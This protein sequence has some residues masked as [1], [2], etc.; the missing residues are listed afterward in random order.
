M[1]ILNLEDYIFGEIIHSTPNL[2]CYIVTDKLSGRQRMM[3][4]IEIR[5]LQDVDDY[6]NEVVVHTRLITHA[7]IVDIVGRKLVFHEERFTG[8]TRATL[9][10][11]FEKMEMTLMEALE[12][13][14]VGEKS[15]SEADI[16][17]MG[18]QLVEGLLHLKC[19]G[20]WHEG[21]G[22]N[23][24]FLDQDGCYKMGNFEYAMNDARDIRKKTFSAREIDFLAPEILEARKKDRSENLSL[25]DYA[26]AGMYSLGTVLAAVRSSGEV[27]LHLR[28]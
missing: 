5:D 27:Y 22:L 9:Y 20:I 26:F 15:F 16:K 19:L 25:E 14:K 10:I 13:A 17:F 23:D 8:K 2:E 1:D 24:I 6:Y 11:A 3:K 12:K 4:V 18:T 28:S 7:S 21:F